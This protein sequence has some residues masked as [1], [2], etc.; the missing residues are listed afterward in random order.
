MERERTAIPYSFLSYYFCRF[1]HGGRKWGAIFNSDI[2]PT[3]TTPM[4]KTQLFLYL[5]FLI[6]RSDFKVGT[7][8]AEFLPISQRTF[9]TDFDYKDTTKNSQ[10]QIIF[11]PICQKKQ[12]I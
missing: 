4:Q 2:F 3:L 9:S 12:T 6:R 11:T 8:T 1:T 5:Q 10:N 7:L